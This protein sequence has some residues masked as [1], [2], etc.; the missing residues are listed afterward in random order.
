MQQFLLPPAHPRR[1]QLAAPRGATDCHAHVF[2]PFERFPL[3]AERHYTPAE[4]HVEHYLR[5]LDDIGFERG[6]LV[7]PTAHGLDCSALLNALKCHPTRLRGVAVI[8]PDIS[9]EELENMQR[10][11][12]RGARFSRPPNGLDKGFVGI[13]A[14]ERLAPRLARLGW[15]AQILATC[16][17]LIHVAPRLLELGLPLVVDHMGLFDSNCGVADL[18]FQML[19]RLFRAGGLWIKLTPYRLSA[20]YPDYDDIAPYHEALLTTRPDRLLWGSDWPHVHMQRD[21]PDVGHLVDL[22][23]RWTNNESLRWR[24]L[25][26]NPAT[27][28]GFADG[29]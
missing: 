1:P 5:T 25:V 11:G 8:A 7:Q 4:L 29:A 15:H 2:G 9:D 17:H 26:Q 24:I 22:F 20:G 3:Q 21:M 28:Y 27:L 12:V 10:C 23:D 18:R 19:L 13:E 6:V 16:D 14:L